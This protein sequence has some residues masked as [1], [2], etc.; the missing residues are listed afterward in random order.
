[1]AKFGNG[2]LRSGTRQTDGGYV[3]QVQQ[4]TDTGEVAG[5]PNSAPASTYWAYASGTG[6]LT[7]TTDAVAATAPGATLRNYVT[8]IQFANSAA[9]ASEIVIKDGS[10]VIW[11]GYV[12]ATTAN[13]NSMTFTPP[14]KAS[15]NAAINIAMIT[16]ATAT[17][18]SAQGYTGA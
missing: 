13:M 2:D 17:R 4:V 10:T 3:Q 12:P 8:G 18:V 9:V 15:L 1:M 5:G 6:G 16:T 11:R 14:L 7:T